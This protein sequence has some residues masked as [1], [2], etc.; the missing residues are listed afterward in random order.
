ML[1]ALFLSRDD[2]ARGE[3][4][5]VQLTTWMCVLFVGISALYI[6][7]YIIAGEPG[8][9]GAILLVI[10]AA[11]GALVLNLRG[12]SLIARHLLL[13]S[14][15]LC[16][17]V[18]S[19]W[20]GPGTFVHLTFLALMSNTILLFP[21]QAWRHIALALVQPL[22][23]L[24]ILRRLP[25]PIPIF[26]HAPPSMVVA[27]STFAS[28]LLTGVMLLATLVA[29]SRAIM[30]SDRLAEEALS[31]LDREMSLVKL[32]QD[33][34]IIANNAVE[35]EKAVNAAM[36]RVLRLSGWRLGRFLPFDDVAM[37]SCSFERDVVEFSRSTWQSA[38]TSTGW[39]ERCRSA[40]HAPGDMLIGV[41]VLVG[42]E[43]AGMMQFASPGPTPPSMEMLSNLDNIGRQLG[44]VE[45]RRRAQ[46]SV[47]ESHIKMIAAAKMATLGEMAGGIAH[48]IN[49]PLSV[50]Q[51]YL[52]R[53]R[54]VQSMYSGPDAVERTDEAVESINGTIMRI[55]KIVNGLRAFA[56][57]STNDPFEPVTIQRLVQDTLALSAERFR[58]KGVI[59]EIE[60]VPQGLTV[61]CRS[62][63]ISQV[64]MNLLNNSMDAVLEVPDRSARR[65]RIGAV[66]AGEDVE[67]FVVDN[68]PGIPEQLREKVMQ[69][70]FTTKPVGQGTGLGLSISKGIV[71]SH[72]GGLAFSSQ[73]GVTEFRVRLPKEQTLEP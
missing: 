28:V 72:N 12:R 37:R 56:R 7:G 63:Q 68:G 71:E 67:I 1:T 64:L 13:A 48:E 44:M 36:Q 58:N 11:L 32:L 54:K 19:A 57:D 24:L 45:E 30:R 52:A 21:P 43:V 29:F 66:D 4:R 2:A 35:L 50:I 25:A 27:A 8:P 40:L 38:A 69:P 31:R 47:S 16:I 49:N 46:R 59:L 10:F 51:G 33:V 73:P 14:S 41:P 60:A 26:G 39:C 17:L 9:I 42:R 15:N 53:I 62:S 65:V 6:A 34:A 61:E 18:F 20:L 55:T 22:I 3:G 23:Y 70:F 5:Y